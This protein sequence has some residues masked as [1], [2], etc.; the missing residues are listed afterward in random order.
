MSGTGVDAVPNLPKCPA[1]VSIYGTEFT[2]VSGTG[3]I[4]V[5]PAP[6]Q[7][8]A[9]TGGNMCPLIYPAVHGGTCVVESSLCYAG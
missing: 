6:V 4:D 9:Y 8:G 7:L 2:E 5:I 1:P 3:I